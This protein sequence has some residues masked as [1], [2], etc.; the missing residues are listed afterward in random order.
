MSCPCTPGLCTCEVMPPRRLGLG[1]IVLLTLCAVVY[2][3]ALTAEL[4]LP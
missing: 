2:A 4:G 1:W 3:F